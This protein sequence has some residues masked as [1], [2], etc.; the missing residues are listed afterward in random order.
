MPGDYSRRSFVRGNGYAAVQMQQGRVLTDADFNEQVDIGQHRTHTEAVD[1]VG[2]S[3]APRAGGGFQIA[4]TGD[5]GDLH[6]TSGRMY[7]GG[8]LCENEPAAVPLA[9]PQGTSASQASLGGLVVGRRA[10]EPGH[11]MEIVALDRPAMVRRVT[12][13]ND[14]TNVVTFDA[15]ISTFRTAAEP[16]LRRV[17][18]YLTQPFYPSP[19][20]GGTPSSPPGFD[21]VQLAPGYHLAYLDAWQREVTAL[22]DPHIKEVALGGPDTTTRLANVW[23]VRLL[24]VAAPG[25]PAPDCDDTFAAWTERTTTATGRLSARTAPPDAEANPCLLPPSAGFRGL[26]NQLYRIQVHKGGSRAEATF[27]VSREN[28]SVQTGITV[29]GDVI[30]A[31]DLGRDDKL[32][33]A[34]GQWVEIVGQAAALGGPPHPLF[35]IKAPDR[36]TR[37]IRTEASISAFSGATGLQLRRW[38]QT[39]SA[40]TAD[41]IPMSSGWVDIEDGIQV[42]FSEGRYHPGDYWLVPARTATG[43]VEW[44]PFEAPNLHPL[45][46]P[47]VGVQHHYCRLALLRVSASGAITVLTDCRAV[48]PPLTAI[49][50]GDVSFDNTACHD[51]MP[52]VTTVQDAIEVLCHGGTGTCTVHVGPGDDVQAAFDRIAANASARVCFTAGDF[53]LPA[54]VHVQG[55][56]HVT[57]VG[58]G[59]GSRLLASKSETALE[60]QGCASVTVRDLTIEAG[61]A[62]G[63]EKQVAGLNGALTFRDCRSVDVEHVSLRC[64]AAAR[65]LASC[66]TVRN[67]NEPLTPMTSARVRGCTLAVGHLQTGVLLINVGRAQVEDNVLHVPPTFKAGGIGPLVLDKV[68]RKKLRDRMVAH[69]VMGTTAPPGGATNAKIVFGGQTLQFKTH[70]GLKAEWGKLLNAQPPGP[71]VNTSEKL[72]KYVT[73]K[74]DAILTDA[75]TRALLPGFANWF[76]TVD[77]GFQDGA[78]QGIVVGGQLARDVRILNNTIENALQPVHVGLSDVTPPGQTPAALKAGSVRIAGNTASVLVGA[79]S[80]SRERHGVFVGNADS[81]IV[82]DNTITLQRLA[83]AENVTITAAQLYGHLGRRV[84]VR[85]NHVTGFNTGV[86]VTPRYQPGNTPYP[87]RESVLWLV[88][89]NMFQNVTTAVVVGRTPTGANA[90]VDV[91]GNRQLV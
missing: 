14:L 85:N 88:A 50:A 36:T 83:G 69:V 7:A 53:T 73:S 91:T 6:I 78:W 24:Q 82:E 31:D 44:E 77:S 41:G 67:A 59:F 16:S 22:D 28:A 33:F 43:D 87:P 5:G 25:S 72:L 11:W 45:A 27:K 21:T 48:F 57:V 19:E 12:T 29:D 84:L 49:T 17:V 66:L 8:L 32:G 56:G 63:K 13:V 64:A 18:T 54:R 51:Q 37:E 86:N 62:A 26:E 23:Q 1:V 79:D 65:R 15:D 40:A 60:F 39:G 55:K 30:T 52:G 81:V 2:A 90:P 71:D 80:I 58:A 20:F 3:G 75:A 46:L 89:D 4:L 38:D 34:G 42:R 10:V 9:F 35:Q 76:T 61:L 68:F 47:P 74:A 70:P